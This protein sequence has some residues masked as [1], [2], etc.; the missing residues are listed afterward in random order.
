MSE[1]NGPTIEWN[2]IRKNFDSVNN[3]DILF[4]FDCC[5]AGAAGKH[6]GPSNTKELLAACGSEDRT[7]AKNSFTLRLVKCFRELLKTDPVF[8]VAWLFE[9]MQNI[10]QRPTPLHVNLNK[11]RESI[12][13]TSLATSKAE[14]VVPA[15]HE[16]LNSRLSTLPMFRTRSPSSDASSQAMSVFSSDQEDRFDGN[17]QVTSPVPE[18]AEPETFQYQVLITVRLKKDVLPEAKGWNL[19]FPSRQIEGVKDVK[20][21]SMYSTRSTL[22]LVTMPVRYWVLLREHPAYTFIDFV[23]S[24]DLL[25]PQLL[26]PSPEPTPT[27]IDPVVRS[28]SDKTTFEKEEIISHLLASMLEFFDKAKLQEHPKERHPGGVAHKF[29]QM[30]TKIGLHSKLESDPR[31]PIIRHMMQQLVVVRNEKGEYEGL[32]Y[33]MHFTEITKLFELGKKSVKEA[34]H[35]ANPKNGEL[36]STIT[37]KIDQLEKEVLTKF[38]SEKRGK[39]YA[40]DPRVSMDHAKPLAQSHAR[41]RSNVSKHAKFDNSIPEDREVL[42]PQTSAQVNSRSKPAATTGIPGN[43]SSKSLRKALRTDSM[44]S[45]HNPPPRTNSG[46]AASRPKIGLWG[47]KYSTVSVNEVHNV[48]RPT[49]LPPSSPPILSYV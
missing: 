21:R 26:V 9:A 23:K 24:G 1:Q 2:D 28:D 34:I 22:L 8:Q 49:S 43:D 3:Q 31:F 39:S 11:S 19:D 6:K 46:S 12:R 10:S 32:S 33:N 35:K 29:Q 41:S 27:G 16:V 42:T 15:T 25:H 7:P 40:I 38:E 4:I 20:V 17:T 45:K 37:T 44:K 18:S 47:R 14:D 13:L 5:F 36:E 48:Q 30:A